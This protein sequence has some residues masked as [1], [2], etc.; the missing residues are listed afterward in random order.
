M[1]IKRGLK[2]RRGTWQEST[3][4]CQHLRNRGPQNI[5]PSGKGFTVAFFKVR[6]IHALKFSR[7]KMHLGDAFGDENYCEEVLEN[8]RN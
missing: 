2:K 8:I 5:F 3:S 4:R 7:A 1:K 6:L